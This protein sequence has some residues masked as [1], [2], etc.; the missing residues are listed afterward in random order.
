MKSMEQP[1][2][3]PNPPPA[4]AM[5]QEFRDFD[6]FAETI[7]G[8]GLDW[9]QLDRG[10]LHARLQQVATPSTLL[11]RFHFSR[12]FHQ[13]GTNPPGTRTFGLLGPKSPHMEW[14]GNEGT[15]NHIVV[16][17]P[18][19]EFD[20]VSHAGFHGDTVSISQDRLR[21]VADVMGVPDL[22]ETLPCHQAIIEADPLRVEAV[23]QSLTGTHTSVAAAHDGHLI[24]PACAEADFEI[25]AALVAALATSRNSGSH[26][27][28]PALRTKAVQLA[29]DYIEDHA[30]EPPTIE[31]ICRASGTS[32]RTLNYA[33]RD[34]FGVTPKQY[35]QMVRLQRVRR[36]LL[37]SDPDAP[38]SET[39]AKWGFWHM[40][41]FAAD[42]RRQFGEL[43]SETARGA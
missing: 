13:R 23:R 9:V 1:V 26:V 21:S 16:F 28:E 5:R 30:D 42:Y 34:Q 27:E 8:W 7:L 37:R 10:P 36:D 38:I 39:A 31:K 24:R 41:A 40:G 18:N 14:R 3:V 33:F 2:T 11:T 15:G 6:E 29:L 32:W 4:V 20:C 35:L 12:K 19:D 17:P 22:L 43:P 25:V